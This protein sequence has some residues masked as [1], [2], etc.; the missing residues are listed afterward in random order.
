LGYSKES[1]SQGKARD[2]LM[3]PPRRQSNSALPAALTS[4]ARPRAAAPAAPKAADD[5]SDRE[6]SALLDAWETPTVP[7]PFDLET[8]AHDRMADDD[9]RVAPSD[10]PTQPAPEE[11]ESSTRLKT[12][13]PISAEHLAQKRIEELRAEL[14]DEFFEGNYGPALILAEAL[15][16]RRPEDTSALDYATECRRM[17][18]KEYLT[19]IGATVAC[20]PVVAISMRELPQKKLDPRAAFLLSRVDGESSLEVLLDLGTMPRLETL[21]LVAELVEARVLR[22]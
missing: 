5:E 6:I 4:G 8:F 14:A 19:R 15:L 12:R 22:I 18:E 16:A 20:V 1:A 17:L 21:R 3:R 10:R 11:L 9:A 13:Q 2:F 7:P